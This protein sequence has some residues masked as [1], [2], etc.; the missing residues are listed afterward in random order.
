MVKGSGIDSAQSALHSE[1]I[2]EMTQVAP[3]G[4][5]ELQIQHACR[6][7]SRAFMTYVPE[8]GGGSSRSQPHEDR[9]EQ[10][11]VIGDGRRFTLALAGFV[12]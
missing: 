8:V 5:L 6:W 1:R 11:E 4:I 10:R 9:V 12:V 7:K 3:Q 2:G